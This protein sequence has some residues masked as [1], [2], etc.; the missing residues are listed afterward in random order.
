MRRL[1]ILFALIAM[2]ASMVSARLYTGHR[3]ASVASNM[4]S[5]IVATVV[6]ARRFIDRQMN[7]LHNYAPQGKSLP[8]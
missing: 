6:R 8:G 5:K 1:A 2:M 3:F 7:L 4:A